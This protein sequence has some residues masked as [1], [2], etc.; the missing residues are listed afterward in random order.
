M[1]GKALSLVIASIGLHRASVRLSNQGGAD[2]RPIH[3][4]EHMG[5]GPVGITFAPPPQDLGV[6]F[7][8]WRGLVWCL[9]DFFT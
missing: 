2:L 5:L 1:M 6:P 7:L 9:E 4:F 3:K 8:G